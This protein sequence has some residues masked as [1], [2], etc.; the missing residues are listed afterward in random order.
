MLRS[1]S[2]SRT[3]VNLVSRRAPS[4]TP[5]TIASTTSAMTTAMTPRGST[6]SFMKSAARLG[7]YSENR[8]QTTRATAKING[9][10]LLVTAA[11]S[12]SAAP[13]TAMTSGPC[14]AVTVAELRRQAR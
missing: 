9:M 3:R 7:T 5:L 14:L 8:Y 12:I 10:E 11:I 2:P 4:T 13:R 6:V 1:T